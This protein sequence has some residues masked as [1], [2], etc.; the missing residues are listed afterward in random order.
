MNK[1]EYNLWVWQYNVR[2]TNIITMKDMIISKKAKEK[3]ILLEDIADTTVLAE[4]AWVLSVV[5]LAGRYN[6]AINNTD[7]DTAKELGLIGIKKY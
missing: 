1:K 5:D 2:H 3:E 6:W 4:V 7:L